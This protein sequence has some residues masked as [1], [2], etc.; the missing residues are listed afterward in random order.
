MFLRF[1]T[2]F[3]FLTSN[4]RKNKKIK[5]SNHTKKTV[6]RISSSPNAVPKQIKHRIDIKWEE[7]WGLQW[8]QQRRR[9]RLTGI[10]WQSRAEAYGTRRRSICE[11]NTCILHIYREM[12]QRI[13]HLKNR[14]L[15]PW[16]FTK[17]NREKFSIDWKNLEYMISSEFSSIKKQ[18]PYLGKMN[19]HIR[20]KRERE[21]A[22]ETKS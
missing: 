2:N 9:Q 1:I 17:K 8:W 11:R 5:Q 20:K 21:R 4:E 22:K 7:E 3:T 19:D 16:I 14:Y 12:N 15:N 10:R 13:C 6:R 18:F